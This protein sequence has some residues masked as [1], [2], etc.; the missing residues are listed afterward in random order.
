MKNFLLILATLF[1]FSCHSQQ[2]GTKLS[3]TEFSNQ[4]K[5]SKD[6]VILD[7]RTPEE[8]AEGFI[9]NAVNLDYNDPH[10]S[11]RV[12]ALDHSKK[13]FVYCLSGGRSSMAANFMRENEFKQVFELDGGVLAW[14]KL[15][16]PLFKEK[17]T[18]SSDKISASEYEA[19]TN[20]SSMV[21]IDF[22]APWCG[23][24][25]QIQP[26]LEELSKEYT[27]KAKIIRINIDE[28]KELT[29]KL[30]IDEIPYFKRYMDGKE[31]GNYIGQLDK[32]TLIRILNGN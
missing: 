25:K 28:N 8:Y 17:T 19:M 16:L 11:N 23:P 2:K 14:N 5:S 9:E 10:F 31:R 13:Y 27:G 26:I 20:Q 24:C 7:V 3:A 29:R 22:Y 6:V 15:K 18:A 32:S 21:L 4:S 12:K 30:G 1:A